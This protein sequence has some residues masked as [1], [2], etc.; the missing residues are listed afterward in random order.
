[1]KTFQWLYLRL[2]LENCTVLPIK[3]PLH[4]TQVIITFD[5]LIGFWSFLYF[6]RKFFLLFDFALSSIVIQH[7]VPKLLGINIFISLHWGT[8]P[9]DSLSTYLDHCPLSQSLASTWKP[10][11]KP[12][13]ISILEH[14]LFSMT[15]PFAD[16]FSKPGEQKQARNF[17]KYQKRTFEVEKIQ[18][19]K[20]TTQSF[21]PLPFLVITNLIVTLILGCLE[22]YI[23]IVLVHWSKSVQRA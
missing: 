10:E 6:S 20:S 13:F 9:S 8:W 23:V 7:L 22:Q 17:C 4:L 15:I 3:I 2:H 5:W 11:F 21:N 12:N 14:F 19:N 16:Y 1:M 18:Q